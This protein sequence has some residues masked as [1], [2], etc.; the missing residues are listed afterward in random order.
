M[1][2]LKPAMTLRLRHIDLLPLTLLKEVALV[3]RC[4]WHALSWASHAGFGLIQKV[5]RTGSGGGETWAGSS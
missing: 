4:A 5:R 1:R 2:I 3:I